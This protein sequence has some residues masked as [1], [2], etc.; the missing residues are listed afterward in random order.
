MI[1]KNKKLM[2]FRLLA[3]T[4]SPLELTFFNSILLAIQF[5]SFITSLFL[6]NDFK[7]MKIKTFKF[8]ICLNEFSTL[9]SNITLKISILCSAI[10]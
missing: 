5:F 2:M 3:T 9:L 4:L 6:L 7:R 8:Y 10:V 1:F